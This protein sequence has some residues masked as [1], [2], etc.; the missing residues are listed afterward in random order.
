MIPP[1]PPDIP[2]E[3]IDTGEPPCS[4]SGDDNYQSG[5]IEVPEQMSATELRKRFDPNPNKTQAIFSE[6]KK[7]L[8]LRKVSLYFCCVILMYIGRPC[9]VTVKPKG[10]LADN[11]LFE[12]WSKTYAVL[13]TYQHST[14]LKFRGG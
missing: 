11:L 6:I 13:Y 5:I 4:S 1:P 14:K 7:G 12:N 8:N 9:Y 2:L 3:L 10:D